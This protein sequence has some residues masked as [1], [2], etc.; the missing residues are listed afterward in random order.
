MIMT[1]GDVVE[2]KGYGRG[3]IVQQESIGIRNGVEIYNDRYL[4]IL[5]NPKELQWVQNQCGGCSFWK[6]EIKQVK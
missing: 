4:I 6:S 5:D 2:V 1:K 3:T